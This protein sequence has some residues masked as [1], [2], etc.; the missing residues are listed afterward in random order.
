MFIRIRELKR[1]HGMVGGAVG[2]I[3]V[4]LFGLVAAPS[5]A[6][7]SVDGRE[8]GQTI[9]GYANRRA[10][11]G[12]RG[13][14]RSYR[15]AFTNSGRAG[16]SSNARSRNRA[17]PKWQDSMVV[18][19]AGTSIASTGSDNN[20][21]QSIRRTYDSNYQ[22]SAASYVTRIATNSSV[23]ATGSRTRGRVQQTSFEIN[24]YYNTRYRVHHPQYVYDDLSYRRTHSRY[25]GYGYSGYYPYYGYGFSFFPYSYYPG[26]SH[27]S[28][29]STYGSRY[30][31]P[32]HSNSYRSS[33]YGQGIR[34]RQQLYFDGSRYRS[35]SYRSS[36]YRSGRYGY[37]FRGHYGYGSGL[38]YRYGNYGHAHFGGGL[39]VH[40]HF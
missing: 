27:Y 34:H 37:G 7:V 28:Y 25:S 3:L 16:S 13:V 17:D 31:S 38:G 10:Y 33:S 30:Y 29:G 22:K 26:Y 6:Q 14:A 36:S 20:N 11:T 35:H 4:F 18:A 15:R 1:G 8:E 9:Q 24:P 5:M 12:R 32:S 39:S 19:V 2:L 21:S 23:S 40:L